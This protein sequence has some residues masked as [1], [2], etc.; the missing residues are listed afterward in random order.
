M[1]NVIKIEKKYLAFRE[2]A[3]KIMRRAQ[4]ERADKKARSF[5]LD[6]SQVEF[7]S[8]SFADEF[9]NSVNALENSGGKVTIVNLKPAL[10]EFV[11]RIDERKQTMKKEMAAVR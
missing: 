9:L 6:F 1:E 11:A 5:V 7:M 2:D 8:R 4:G 3:K 10:Q